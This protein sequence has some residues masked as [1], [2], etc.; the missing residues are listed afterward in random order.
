MSDDLRLALGISYCGTAFSGWES[1]RDK[2]TVQAVLEDALSSVA[3]SGVA[4]SC[5]G[6]TD[7]GVHAFGQVVHFDVSVSR[8]DAAWLYGT[9]TLLPPDVSVQWVKAVP[10]GFHARFSAVSR[11]Y[12]YLLLNRRVRCPLRANSAGWE[13]RPLSL[14]AMRAASSFLVGSHDFSSFQSSGCQAKTPD[15]TVYFVTVE[16]YS[17]MLVIDIAADAF[18]Q[19]MV[20]NIVGT[21][22][23]VGL[24]Q[25]APSWVA[26]VLARRDRTVA[27]AT[28]AA[29]GLY[30]LKVCY[31][32]DYGIPVS[33]P[34]PA[35]P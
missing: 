9:N 6:R 27:G 12:R 5:A 35:F 26:E 7:S 18:L 2:R 31:P 10:P 8:P 15:R 14:A 24:E 4:V 11:H 3:A 13:P 33:Q 25:E 34:Y 28:A 1:Q 23:K 32:C 21:L 30:L 20:R 17:D 19:K 29:D 16:K 22:V